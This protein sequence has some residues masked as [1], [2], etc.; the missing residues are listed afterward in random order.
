MN[1]E[2]V[3]CISWQSSVMPVAAYN[4]FHQRCYT[5]SSFSNQELRELPVAE[6]GMSAMCCGCGEYIREEEKVEVTH[7]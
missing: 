4:Y 7:V 1:N 5:G 6:V 2:I 3:I